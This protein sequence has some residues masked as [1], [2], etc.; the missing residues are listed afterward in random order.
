MTPRAFIDKWR[1]VELKERSAAQSHFIDLCRL[2]DVDDPVTADP[3]GTWFTFEMGASK[4]SGGEGWADVWRR[5]CFGWEYKGKKKDLDAAFGQLLQ[6]A[7]ALENPPLLIVSDMDRIRVHTNF[8]NTVQRV[9]ELTLDDLL[10]G[11][12]RDLLRAAFVEP[13]RFKPTTTRQGLTE[14]AAKRFAGLA[15]RLRARGHAPETVAH[16]VNRLVFCMFAED[17]GLLPN[18]LF[19]RML[20][21]CA[22]APFEFEGHAAVLFQAMQGGGRVGFE[23]VGWFNGGLFDDD[24]ALPL[25]QADVDD[26]REAARLD[27]SE[28]DPSILGTLFERGLDPDKRSQLGAHYTDRDKI[29]LIVNPV[30]VRPLEA[31]WAETKAGIDAALAKA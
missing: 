26:L 10:D 24:T 8:T 17:V 15:L 29:M 30:I 9:H 7:I 25:E 18:K 23:A 3:K 13:E 31:E 1:G 14:E 27:W 11:A 19:T 6:Y 16:F 5:G 21:G 20:E 12:K 4:T 22:R 2:L 28:I